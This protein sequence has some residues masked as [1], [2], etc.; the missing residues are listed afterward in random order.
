ML[1]WFG[2]KK[3]I[4]NDVFGYLA[5]I[6][7]VLEVDRNGKDAVPLVGD[8]QPDAALDIVERQP[9]LYQPWT[10]IYDW[11]VRG[12]NDRRRYCA[13]LKANLRQAGSGHGKMEQTPDRKQTRMRLQSN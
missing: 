13:V 4:Q 1:V 11:E 8:G 5:S 9:T 10:S 7:W 3:A 6:L 12:M 2:P